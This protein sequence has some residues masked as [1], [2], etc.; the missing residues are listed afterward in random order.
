MYFEI[1]SQVRNNQEISMFRS[2]VH[3]FAKEVVRPASLELDRMDYREAAAKDSPYFEVLRK[4]KKNGYHRVLIPDEYGGSMVGPLEFN[5]FAE[6]LAWGG[7]GLATAIGVCQLGPAVASLVGSPQVIDE[8]VRPW[9]EDEGDKY[10]GCW[11]VM[12]PDRGSDYI[13]L[14]NEPDPESYGLKGFL[15]AER[16]GDGWVLNGTKSY[17]TSSGP[18]ANW[19]LVHPIIPPHRSAQDCGAALVPLD[20][21]GVTNSGPI[22]KI[23]LRDDPQ[24]EIIFDNVKI[25]DH[26]MIA[27]AAD[28]GPTLMKMIISCTSVYMGGMFVGVARA[29]FEEALKYCG[30]RVQG[31]VPI[32]EHQLTRYRLFNMFE[33]IETARAYLR[34]ATRNVW[35]EVFQNHTYYQ[36]TSHAMAAQT[37]CK[38]MA[39]DVTHDALQL[40]G[41]A[42]TL[43]EMPVEKFFRDAR[44][45]LIMDGCSE[46]LALEGAADMLEEDLYTVD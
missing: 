24:G 44:A 20:L 16:E 39:F 35:E 10:D 4:M 41:G 42:G 11:C 36:S 45:A 6:E 46:I 43:K 5:I 30:E 18:C 33:K 26:Y 19:A 13:M 25:P 34:T 17:W 12:D 38:N 7:A 9:M 27:Q 15:I 2:E 28:F 23:G 22:D 29:A 1:D 31:K 8:V 37:Y 40:H 21:P 32:I 14:F 3:R